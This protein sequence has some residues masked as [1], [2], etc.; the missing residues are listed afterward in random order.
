M[1]NLTADDIFAVDDSE[2]TP[3]DVPQWGGTIYIRVMNAEEAISFSELT[4]DPARRKQA[5]LRLV[6]MCCCN[7][8]GEQLFRPDQVEKLKKK[9]VKVF[10]GIQ[11]KIFE[12][13]SMRDET[14]AE[15]DEAK[16]A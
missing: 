7:E 12:I 6:T 10:L 16:N 3:Y 5:M 13:N 9:S 2:L 8:K 11:N 14:A 1:K 15:K 4:A